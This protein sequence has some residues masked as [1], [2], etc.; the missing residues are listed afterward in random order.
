MRN[1]ALTELDGVIG[2][3]ALTMTD[4]W[5]LESRDVEVRGEAT[6]EW[7]GDVAKG[8]RHH[9]RPQAIC[10][11]TD[12]TGLIPGVVAATRAGRLAAVSRYSS[13][14]ITAE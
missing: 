2:Q 6:I 3:W 4:A 1:E 10:G 5:F 7:L 11:P 13:S 14:A 12:A 8:L 9:I